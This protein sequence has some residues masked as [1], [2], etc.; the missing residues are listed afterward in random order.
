LKPKTILLN[1]VFA[2]SKNV[3]AFCFFRLGDKQQKQKSVFAMAV[4]DDVVVVLWHWVEISCAEDQEKRLWVHPINEKR[5]KENTLQNFINELRSDNKFRNFT[6]M[7]VTTFDYVLNVISDK[8]RK[9][10]SRFRKSI[11]PAQR[12][13]VTLRFVINGNFLFRINVCY[14]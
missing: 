7:S 1:N 14:N 9:R 2:R 4:E 5:S 8:I 12:L 11:P 13:F 3:F 10:D 6:R